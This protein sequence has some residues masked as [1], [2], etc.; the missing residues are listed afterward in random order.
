MM[1][2]TKGILGSMAR[3]NY[4][5]RGDEY[6]EWHR[7]IQDDTFKFLDLDCIEYTQCTNCG[8]KN[9]HFIAE[10]CKFKGKTYKNTEITRL[11]AQRMKVSAFL[12]FYYYKNGQN[13]A[14]QSEILKI[15]Y[16]PYLFL[17][18]AKIDH[19]R[20][21]TGYVFKDFTSAEWVSYLKKLRTD[22]K[23]EYCG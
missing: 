10:T 4:F 12:I 13:P 16:D 19:L 14:T 8:Q 5:N 11:L 17:K 22:M 3:H 20:A 18:I 23:C 9:I 1:H 6:S 15:G 7:N 21:N 2:N